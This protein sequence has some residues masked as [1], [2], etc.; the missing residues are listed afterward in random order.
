MQELST[1]RRSVWRGGRSGLQP[2]RVLDELVQQQC[3]VLTAAQARAAG[4]TRATIR[5]HLAAGRWRRVHDWVY[6]TVA[7]PLPRQAQLWAAVLRAGSG[8][9]LSHISAAEQV[10][11]CESGAEVHLTIPTRRR[12]V[13]VPGSVI[14]YRQCAADIRH[15]S[16]TPPQTRVEHTVIDLTQASPS[17]DGAVDWLIRACAGRVTTAERLISVLAGQKKIRWRA[18]L[19]RVLEDVASGCHSVLERRYLHDVE[20]AHGLPVASRQ[21]RRATGGGMRY[22]DVYYRRFHLTVELDGRV[23]HP[24]GTHWRDMYRD[25]AAVAAGNRVL[26]Y[27]WTDVVT[28]RARWLSRWPPYLSRPAGKAASSRAGAQSA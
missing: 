12:I 4:V 18:E 2:G 1:G 14:H 22:D 13:A 3:G 23:A 21:A 25:N 6:A 7:V 15:P 11:L 17:L 5:A 16:R 8:A 28:N 26:R 20:R 10:G 9:M 27:G 24:D 19:S